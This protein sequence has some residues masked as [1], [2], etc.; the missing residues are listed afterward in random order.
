MCQLHWE[1]P[2]VQYGGLLA[3]AGDQSSSVAEIHVVFESIQYGVLPVRN[4]RHRAS[5]LLPAVAQ[6]VLDHR[7]LEPGQVRLRKHRHRPTIAFGRPEEVSGARLAA[8]L[9]WQVV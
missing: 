4:L 3:Q 1:G 5:S 2:R 9:M 7:W 8:G 6:F